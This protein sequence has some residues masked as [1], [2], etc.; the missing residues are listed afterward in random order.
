MAALAGVGVRNAASAESLA[1]GGEE[2]EAQPAFKERGYYI[3]FMRGPLFTFE[4][5]KGILDGVKEDGGTHVILWMGGAFPSRKFPITWKYNAEHENVK[6]NFA[7]KLIDHGHDLGLK[8]LLC[9]TPFAYDGANQYTIEHPELKALNEW[10]G[11]TKASG[12]D[13]WG[14]NLNPYREESQQFMLEY[15]REMLE[16]YPNADGLLLESSDYAISYCKDC[17]KTFYQKEF[18]FVRKISD[19]LW[20]C[21]PDATI[22]VYPHYFTG[23]DVPGMKINGAKEAFDPRWT[24]FFTLHSAYLDTELIRKARSS[25]YWDPSPSFG[26]PALIRA[27]AQ[28]AKQAGATGYIPSFDA[29][30]YKYSGP[31]MGHQFLVGTRATPF[32]FGWLKPGETPM[33][34][35]LLRLDRLA[36]REYSWTP[37]CSAKK[38]RAT[39]ARELFHDSASNEEIDDLFFLEETFTLDRTWDMAPVLSSPEVVKGRIEL[40][41]LSPSRLMEYRERLKRVAG[42]SQRSAHSSNPAV[43]EMGKTAAWISEQWATSPDGHVLDLH[44]R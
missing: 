39:V 27:A 19:E 4:V 28:K 2:R 13:A 22:A 29:W 8:V 15:T 35:M 23:A 20:A 33:H 3:T 18:E 26:Q 42:I 43:R 10:G 17:P 7:G 25:F 40:G 34:E 37:D 31:D 44:L 30:N 6:H 14:F 38:F 11:Y 21:K 16:F 24:L 41:E 1:I 9:L 5:W 12:L 32:C 36:Y